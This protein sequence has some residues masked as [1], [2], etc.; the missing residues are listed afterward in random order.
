MKVAS[1]TD[2]KKI[3]DQKKLILTS[4]ADRLVSYKCSEQISKLWNCPV[5]YH[6][7]AGHDLPLDDAAWVIERIKEEFQ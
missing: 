1:L 6:Q 7:E 2:F 4:K 5:H 3:P